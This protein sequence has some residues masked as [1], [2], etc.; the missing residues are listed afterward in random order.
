M[1]KFREMV[2]AKLEEKQ[3]FTDLGWDFVPPAKFTDDQEAAIKQF[4]EYLKQYEDGLLGRKELITKLN[5]LYDR[6]P[7][8]HKPRD[9]DAI[10][11]TE[12]FT[13]LEY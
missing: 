7:D 1:S 11:P 9:K 12:L 3:N 6:L 2:K 13:D 8:F 5:S 10:L 4:S